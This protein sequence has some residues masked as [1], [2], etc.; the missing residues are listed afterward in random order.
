MHCNGRIPSSR[1][2]RGREG[3]VEGAVTSLSVE[4][5]APSSSVYSQ[6]CT[7]TAPCP[8]LGTRSISTSG[9][10]GSLHHPPFRYWCGPIISRGGWY[11]WRQL[12]TTHA[13]L[14]HTVVS[15]Q[16][17]PVSHVALHIRV[18]PL[19][20]EMFV[21]GIALS[22]KKGRICFLVL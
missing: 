21:V 16:A 10:F 6:A 7:R 4:R 1:N 5:A 20:L 11:D 2:R 12:C 22:Q 19:A 8:S 14:E 15:K 9:L 18:D 17:Y 3:L 13:V